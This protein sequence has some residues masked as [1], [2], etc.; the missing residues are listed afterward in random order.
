MNR[1]SKVV[2][3]TLLSFGIYFLIDETYF[4]EIRQWF[5]EFIDQWGISHIMAYL[6]VGIPIFIGT[7]ILHKK[8]KFFRSLGLDKCLLLKGM[9]FSLLCTLPMFIGFVVLF[10]FNTDFSLN[11]FLISIIAAALFEETYFRGFLFGQIYRFTNW[12][13]IPS[14]L[15]GAILFGLIHLYQGTD[16]NELTGIFL[17]TF[18]GGVLYAW[19]YVE[20]NYNL[21]VPI[22]LHLFMNLSWGLFSVAEN[23]LGGTYAN[24]FRLITIFLIIGLTVAYKIKNKLDFNINIRTLLMKETD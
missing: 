15:I 21:W 14:V 4:K 9:V 16:L 10:D 20:W 19:V 23:A 13:F 2:L 5:Y 3:T 24:I 17:I 7:L 6:I 18:L 22:F 12:G 1:T 8:N 11:I